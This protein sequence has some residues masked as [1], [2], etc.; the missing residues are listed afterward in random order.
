MYVDVLA[1]MLRY[2][3]DGD[4]RIHRKVSSRGDMRGGDRGRHLGDGTMWSS[5]MAQPAQMASPHLKDLES[6]RQE[7]PFR[8]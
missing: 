3:M 6:R 8:S 2:V 4:Y 5:L 7:T 1:S